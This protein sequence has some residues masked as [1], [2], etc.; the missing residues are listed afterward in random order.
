V[1]THSSS[2]YDVSVASG[3]TL[4]LRGL[5]G[6]T[7]WTATCGPDQMVVGFS[8]R[9]GL[10]LDLLELRCAPL[11]VSSGG[12]VSTGIISTLTSVGD[13]GGSAFPTADCPSGEIAT[14]SNLRTGDVVDAF[15]LSCSRPSLVF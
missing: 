4:P 5:V 11:L 15:G 1:L 9:S 3:T 2:G 8:G 6:D 14:I 7:P 13:Q 10:Y 12:V